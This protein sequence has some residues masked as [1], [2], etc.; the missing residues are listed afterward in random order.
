MNT[1]EPQQLDKRVC[2]MLDVLVWE[3]IGSVD[4]DFSVV[5]RW[6]CQ[7]RDDVQTDLVQNYWS[8][9]KCV[10]EPQK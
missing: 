5:P 9:P 10:R 3:K 7:S 1:S 8:N 2:S 6:P 4:V